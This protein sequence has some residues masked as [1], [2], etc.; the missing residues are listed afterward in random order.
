MTY[1]LKEHYYVRRHMQDAALEEQ[2]Y[3]NIV[4]EIKGLL[5]TKTQFIRRRPG[6]FKDY[7]QSP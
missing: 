6:F 1:V 3:E 7:T 2:R 5:K 4:K